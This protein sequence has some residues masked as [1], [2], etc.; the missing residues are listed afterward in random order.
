MA[1]EN[2]KAKELTANQVDEGFLEGIVEAAATGSEGAVASSSGGSG[3]R[4]GGESGGDDAAA[5]SQTDGSA[6]AGSSTAAPDSDSDGVPAALSPAAAGPEAA[7]TRAEVT[8]AEIVQH[9]NVTDAYLEIETEAGEFAPGPP[10]RDVMK[11]GR[12]L[13]LSTRPLF[14]ST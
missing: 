4:G 3:G 14:S 12:A 11:D 7:P 5:L 9:A 13:Q 10:L 6:A 2:R 8:A 1:E